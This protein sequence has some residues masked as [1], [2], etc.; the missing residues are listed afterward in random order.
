ML[1]LWLIDDLE[2]FGTQSLLENNP[3]EGVIACKFDIKLT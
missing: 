1:R 3:C 2:L